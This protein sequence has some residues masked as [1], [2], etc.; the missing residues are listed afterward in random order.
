MQRQQ[1]D[2]P[3][4]EDSD[5][6]WVDVGGD[7]AWLP[8]R[9][10]VLVAVV[11]VLLVTTAAPLFAGSAA[12]LTFTASDVSVVSNN[13]HLESLTVAP[14]GTVQYDGLESEPAS[15]DITVQVKKGSSW[16]TVAT[17]SVS[18]SGLEGTVDYDIAE[19]DL[20]TVLDKSTFHAV[21][22]STTETTVEMRMRASLVGAGPNGDDVRVT[23]SDSFTVTVENE[24]H[25]G[26]MGGAAN[27]NA[28]GK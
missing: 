25:G 22:G 8:G 23:G 9:R 24:K 2:Y 13:G 7:D 16:E 26:S 5:L 1:D 28:T 10:T 14:E 21:P 12:A 17:K 11:A 6:D 4:T 27:T 19:I 3:T 20:L 18:A 15:V